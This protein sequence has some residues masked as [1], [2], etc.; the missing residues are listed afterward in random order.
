MNNFSIYDFCQSG[1]SESQ[2]LS[3]YSSSI[4]ATTTLVS[5]KVVTSLNAPGLSSTFEVYATPLQVSRAL[6]FA[7]SQIDSTKYALSFYNQSIGFAL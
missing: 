5:G 2:L 3:M 7:L 4:S 6:W 1:L